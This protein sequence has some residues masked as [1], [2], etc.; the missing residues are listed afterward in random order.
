MDIVYTEHLRW[1]MKIRGI[2]EN[3]PRVVFEK[4]KKHYYDLQRNHWIAVGQIYY[5]NKFRL[6]IV[7]YD[8]INDT[9]E[10]ITVIQ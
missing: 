5:R 6:M 9:I 10:I 2:P 7:A 3:L 4:A 1:R 8:I